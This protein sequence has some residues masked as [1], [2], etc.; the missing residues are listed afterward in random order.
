[1]AVLKQIKFGELAHDIA[2]TVLT[3]KKGGVMSVTAPINS[4]TGQPFTNGKDEQKDYQ[5][6]LDVNVDDSTIKKSEGKLTVG[7]VPAAQVTVDNTAAGITSTNAQAAF[8]ELKDSINAVGGAAKSYT[9]VKVTKGL[10][11]NVKE[12]YK[13]Q[14]TVGSKIEPVGEPINI[15]KDGSLDSVELENQELVFKYNLA[16]GEQS[17]IRVDVSTFLAESE[18]KDGLQV[19]GD[20]QVSV[21]IDSTSETDSQEKAAAF[22]T[23]SADGIKISGIKDEIDRKIAALDVTNDDAVA[24]QYVAAIQE[25]DGIVSVKTR[26]NVS[27]AVLTGYVKGSAPAAGSKAVTAGDD[28]KGAI[29][30][31]EHQVDAAK[32]AATTKVVE[33]TDAGNNLSIVT[34]NNADGS[35]TYTINLT[36]VASKTALE[37]EITARKAVDGQDGPTYVANNG[38]TYISDA[39]SLNDADVKL[40]AALKAEAGRAKS[41]ETSIDAAIGLTKGGDNETR[42]FTPTTNYGADSRSVV[43]N[44]QK[45]DTALN[46]VSVK[47]NAIQYQVNGTTLEFFGISPKTV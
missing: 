27:D 43:D 17:I 41:A 16:T 8:K 21:K 22:L 42:T 26:A 4:E 47:V 2:K 20:G 19:N 31:L 33:G 10:S 38:T 30:K 3:S 12:Q 34:G 7:N 13:L 18:F 15:Y 1:M 25:T 23:V 11:A 5:Y 39:A 29:A 44:M 32:A 6:E 9:I 40:D 45:L 36:D 37:A 35:T 28:V 14:Q 24:G 46:A